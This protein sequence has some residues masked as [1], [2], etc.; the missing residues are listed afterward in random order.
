MGEGEI[1]EQR[2]PLPSTFAQAAKL[3]R[4]A[5]AKEK[6][7]ANWKVLSWKAGDSLNNNVMDS[8]SDFLFLIP[9]VYNMAYLQDYNSDGGWDHTLV[10]IVYQG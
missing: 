5:A 3:R 1:L 4:L 8:L 9:I 6:E 7:L 2:R 10:D